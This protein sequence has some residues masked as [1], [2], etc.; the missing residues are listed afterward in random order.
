MGR[1]G[2]RSSVV[3]RLVGLSLRV[4]NEALKTVRCLTDAATVG[5]Y[6][7]GFEDGY[8]FGIEHAQREMERTK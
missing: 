4:V 1:D 6:Y 2:R 5:R 8:R 7:C 3:N